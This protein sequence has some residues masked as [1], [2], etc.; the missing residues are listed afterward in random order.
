MYTLCMYS[1]V[2][3]VYY[4]VFTDYTILVTTSKLDLDKLTAITDKGTVY[5]CV[6]HISYTLLF[7]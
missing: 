1:S 6:L 5:M 7:L 3:V 4:V 2:C